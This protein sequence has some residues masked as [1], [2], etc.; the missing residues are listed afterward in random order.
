MQPVLRK[1]FQIAEFREI[2]LMQSEAD[3]LG[4]HWS[5]KK[6]PDEVNDSY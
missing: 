6:L 5:P 2:L 1:Y 3:E 4:F